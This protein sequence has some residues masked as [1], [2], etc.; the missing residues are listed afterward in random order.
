LPFVRLAP[1]TTT[2][3][4]FA[5][6]VH[7]EDFLPHPLQTP[8]LIGLPHFLHG[9]HPQLWHIIYPFPN[10]PAAGLYPAVFVFYVSGAEPLKQIRKFS[11][12]P[13]KI[14]VFAYNSR[15]KLRDFAMTRRDITLSLFAAAVLSIMLA[16]CV[17]RTLTVKTVPEGALVA[18]NDEEIG[19]SP[20]TTSFN[21]YGDYNVRISMPG[22]ETLKTHR[23]LKAPWYDNFPWDFIMN[24]LN[25][26]HIVDEY[27]W[28][29]ELQPKKEIGRE[30][31]I[32]SAIELRDKM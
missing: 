12:R 24:N 27:E 11:V 18:L 1:P 7:S 20:V 28:T 22:Y 8:F 14:Q 6:Q 21:W 15:C 9:L 19:R 30:E 29:F 5:L 31:L 32:K 26:K 3:L 25:P 16:G 23:E 4:Y 17:E 10:F 2:E 13:F